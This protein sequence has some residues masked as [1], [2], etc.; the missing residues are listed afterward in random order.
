M[1]MG[2]TA[3]GCCLCGGGG[4]GGIGTGGIGWTTCVNC[5]TIPTTVSVTSTDYG[6]P[7]SPTGST[8]DFWFIFLAGM[9]LTFL[10]VPPTGY[11]Y[12]QGPGYWSG[13]F[14]GFYTGYTLR[15]FLSCPGP[16]IGWTMIGWY[17]PT[18]V[19]AGHTITGGWSYGITAP[20]TSTPGVNTCN[21]TAPGLHL[22]SIVTFGITPTDMIVIDGGAP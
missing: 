1:G 18:G 14:V 17:D 7:A 22:H 11:N 2:T 13:E 9:S 12:G 5:A 16:S 10:M 21:A 20:G 4:G 3:I 15:M 6:T 19:A 8:D